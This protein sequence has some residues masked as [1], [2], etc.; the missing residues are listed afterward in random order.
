MKW[1]KI[2]AAV[3]TGLLAFGGQA[4]LLSPPEYNAVMAAPKAPKARRTPPKPRQKPEPMTY[5]R[6]VMIENKEHE[7]R[8]RLILKHF[9]NHR[10]LR[11]SELQKENLRHQKRLEEIEKKYGGR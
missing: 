7:R 11:E 5:E 6:A 4:L 3:L 9:K 10:P 1:Q 2:A 8:V